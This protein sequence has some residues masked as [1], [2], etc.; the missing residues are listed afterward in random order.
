MLLYGPPGCSK[1]LTAAAVAHEAGLNFLAV[2]GAEV[3]TMYVG[4]SERKVRDIFSKARAAQ[5]SILFLDE[6]DAVGAVREAGHSGVQVLTTLLNELDGI[7][8]MKGVFV[9][10]ATNKPWVLDPALM[11]PGRLDRIMYVP[12]PD[13]ATRKDIFHIRLG[14]M[15]HDDS[16]N[17]DWLAQNTA[18]FSGAEITKMCQQA[19]Y[20]ALKETMKGQAA[21]AEE[22]PVRQRH[23]QAALD[24]SSRGVSEAMVKEYEEWSRAMK[25]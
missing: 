12:L 24:A 2:K 21:S 22:E 15:K 19:G 9:L 3:L 17:I 18:G 10:A 14:A 6:I 1:T 16:I 5:P 25:R 8:P 23:F 7:E 13:E 4:E 20:E 11:R